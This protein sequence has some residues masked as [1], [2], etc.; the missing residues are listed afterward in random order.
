M[1]AHQTYFI[2]IDC[3][4]YLFQ[5]MVEAECF[6]W[7]LLFSLVLRDSPL[8]VRTIS[9][10]ASLAEKDAAHICKLSSDLIMVGIRILLQQGVVSISFNK[11][12]L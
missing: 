10:A 1:L 5:V 7:C 4:R 9:L 6:D 2:N 12:L 11:P 8:F 3:F